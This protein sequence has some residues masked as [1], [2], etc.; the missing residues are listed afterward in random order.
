MHFIIIIIIIII[1]FYS[2]TRNELSRPM[3]SKIR[4]GPRSYYRQRDEQTHKQMRPK[5]L[6]R[7]ICGL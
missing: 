1:M 3:H 4:V 6:P 7:R 2:H 5:T